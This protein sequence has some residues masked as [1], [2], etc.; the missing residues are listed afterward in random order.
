MSNSNLKISP[1]SFLN[2]IFERNAR[3]GLHACDILAHAVQAVDSHDC[4]F[5]NIELVDNQLL[6]GKQLID[7]SIIDRIFVIGF[8]KAAVPMAKAVMDKLDLRISEAWVVTKDSK[9]LTEN[10]Y[11]NKLSV[12]L[13]GHPVPT[14]KSIKSTQRILQRLPTLTEKDLVMV[15]ISGGG[16]ALL[17]EPIDGISLNDLQIL[18]QT[19]LNCGADIHEINTLRKH[20][21]L[22]KGGRLAE[23]LKPASVHALILSD[24]IGD[25]LDMIA[26]GPTVSDPTTFQDTLEILD[27]YDIKKDIP[28]RILHKLEEGRNGVIPETLK[29]GQLPADRVGHHLVGTNYIAAEAA[30]LRAQSLGYYSEIIST[31]ITERTDVLA[32]YLIDVLQSRLSNRNNNDQPMCLI[33]GGEPTVIVKG[34]GMGGRNMDLTLRMIPKLAKISGTL[35]ISFATDGEDGPTDAAGAAADSFMLNESKDVYGLNLQ[36]Y[37][38]NNDSY[39]YFEQLGGLIKTGATGTN[40]NDLMLILINVQKARN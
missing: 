9:F 35:F 20:L 33:F 13:G 5:R 40:V 28:F 19:L 32:D 37:I 14:D 39:H 27:R 12:F 10:G 21:D 36:A 8:G 17:T 15:V 34:D 4:V 25:R 26:S 2:R 31:T 3:L 23:R 38:E 18:T 24:V 7:L 29:P 11:R 16:S 22:V 6:L 1:E 30:R